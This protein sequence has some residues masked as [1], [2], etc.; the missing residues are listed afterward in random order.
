MRASMIRSTPLCFSISKGVTTPHKHL[1][2]T[3][4]IGFHLV[5]LI[6]SPT[7]HH[8]SLSDRLRSKCRVPRRQSVTDDN[9]DTLPYF[10]SFTLRT[11]WTAGTSRQLGRHNGGLKAEHHTSVTMRSRHNNTRLTPLESKI[12]PSAR[13]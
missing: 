9:K 8:S 1:P 4:L 12:S 10:C 11:V 3:M 2:T 6:M 5:D 13:N 7:D